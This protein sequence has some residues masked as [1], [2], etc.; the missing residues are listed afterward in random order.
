MP[1]TL[2]CRCRLF[3]FVAALAGSLA[4]AGACGTA[5]KSKDLAPDVWASVDGRVIHR[6]DVERAYRRVLQ[7]TATPP[8]DD[9]VLA[10]K[11]SLL[12]ELITQ[13]IL[14]EK[15]RTLKIEVTDAELDAAFADRR[16]S[17][18]DDAFQQEL[19]Q[20]SL[21]VDDMKE[22]L[23]REL[24]ANKVVD[25]DVVS[26][27]VIGDDDV[28]AYYETHRAEFNVAE[29]QYHIAQLV[30]APGREPQLRNRK[31]DDAIT[32]VEALHKADLM[33]ERVKAGADFG[34]LAMD[35]SEDPDS[36]PRGGDLGFVSAT[37]LKQVPAALRD[38]VLKAEPGSVNEVSGNGA[39]TLVMLIARE[40]AGQRDLNTPGVKDGISTGLH[41]RKAQL[42]HAAYITAARNDA[43][44]VNNLARQLVQV[45][46]RLPGLAPAAP[47]K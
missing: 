15:A 6:D 35:Y 4:L 9:E 22:G 7:P 3:L 47:G 14:L 16:K 17:I 36:A 8:S 27:I 23:R 1:Q 25:R 10:A 37:Q 24:I 44:I 28:K 5:G 2:V 45:Q 39:H 29:T 46:G 40:T 20:R 19:R 43:T 30:I 34:Q 31:N 12:D 38:A 26:K 32:A 18:S 41:D 21:T 11:L 13:N 33:M 42:V